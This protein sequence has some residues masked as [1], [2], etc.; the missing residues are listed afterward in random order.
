MAEEVE[1]IREEAAGDNS[2]DVAVSLT[3]EEDLED[4]P[5]PYWSRRIILQRMERG[6]YRLRIAVIQNVEQL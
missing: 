1:I 6:T 3:V 5:R 2:A 4:S